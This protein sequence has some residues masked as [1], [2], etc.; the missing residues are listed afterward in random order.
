MTTLTRLFGFD[1]RTMSVRTEIVAGITTFLTMAYILAVNPNIMGDIGMDRGAVFTTTAI[2]SMFST[3]IMAIYARLPFALAPGMGLNA[4]FAYT[5]CMKMGYDWSFALTAVLIE[6]IAFIILTETNLR[7][8]IVN[9]IPGSIR[10]AI[11]PGIGLYIAFIGL[12]NGGVIASS[13]ATFVTLGH[14]TSGPGLLSIIGLV[15]TGTLLILNVR[16]ALLL[17]IL[18]TTL[19]GI[20]LG[21]TTFAGVAGLPPS[22]APIAFK[23]DFTHIL[24]VDMLIVVLTFL[25]IDMFD[26]IGTLVGVSTKAGLLRDGQVPH[27]KRAFMADAVGTTLGSMMGSSAIATYV[28]S[29]SGVAQGGRS[30]LTAFTTA[31]CFGV[32]LIFAPLFLSIPGSATC[33]VLVIVGLFMLSPIRNIDLDDYAES[34]PAFICLILMPLTYSISDGILIGIISYVVLN[35]LSGKHRK[36]TPAMYILAALFILK[37]IFI[38]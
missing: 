32:A 10:H 27:L 5:V 9:A 13:P 1:P 35:L 16:G 14:I 24:S 18:G 3:L 17:G 12:K 11:G 29:A 36:L 25:F 30:G 31:V 33:P 4:F 26:T 23:F 8:A 2:I 34:L 7:D 38:G 20:P 15:L 19:L 21:Q 22:I 28:E 6:G 37:Y